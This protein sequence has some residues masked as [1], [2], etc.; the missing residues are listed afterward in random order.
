[1]SV[2]FSGFMGK[3]SERGSRTILFRASIHSHE[4]RKKDTHSLY[5]Q[6]FQQEPFLKFSDKSYKFKIP[7]ATGT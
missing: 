1:M 7:K 4:P 5:L 2:F 6:C 3:E